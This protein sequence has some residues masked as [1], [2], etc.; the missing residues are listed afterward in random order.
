MGG[1]KEVERDGGRKGGGYLI[2][3][4]ET[5]PTLSL[6]KFEESSLWHAGTFSPHPLANILNSPLSATETLYQFCMHC[7]GAY[8][9]N[10]AAFKPSSKW[11]CL[12]F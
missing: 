1:R 8:T 2:G 11:L 3:L 7:R 5:M 10:P 12:T 9:T 4:I 6:Y